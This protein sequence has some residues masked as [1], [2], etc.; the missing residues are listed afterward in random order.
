MSAS[1]IEKPRWHKGREPSRVLK[2][3]E[4]GATAKE[5][6]VLREIPKSVFTKRYTRGRWRQ[7]ERALMASGMTSSERAA[8]RER[9]AR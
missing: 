1:I 5:I 4:L 2:A 8:F 6:A 3:I 9:Y 7:F